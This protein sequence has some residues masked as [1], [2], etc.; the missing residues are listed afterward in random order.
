MN[1]GWKILLLSAAV[2]AAAFGA[3]RLLVPDVVPV[4]FAEETQSLWSLET[5]FVLRA[6][7]LMAAGVAVIALVIMLG[8]LAKKLPRRRAL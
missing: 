7:E 1:T 3:E 5:A 2:F 4:A 8:A 6:I